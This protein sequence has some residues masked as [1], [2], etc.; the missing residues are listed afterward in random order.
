MNRIFAMI[1]MTITISIVI[2]PIISIAD[3][4][5]IP[6]HKSPMA[7]SKTSLCEFPFGKMVILKLN[8]ITGFGTLIIFLVNILMGA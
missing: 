1:I 8:M 6:T 3:F 7:G 4:Y 2:N 5:V